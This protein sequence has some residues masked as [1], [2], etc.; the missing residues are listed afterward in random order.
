M[1]A[2]IR[3]DRV[4]PGTGVSNAVFRHDSTPTDF[5]GAILGW[6]GWE[7]A[8]A[9]TD[10][11]LAAF[12][13]CEPGSR[14]VASLVD[15]RDADHH[16]TQYVRDATGR[17]NSIQSGGAVVFLDYDEQGRIVLGRETTGRKVKYTYDDGGRIARVEKADGVVRIYAYN[18]RDRMLT[19]NENES[20]VVD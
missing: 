1:A 16:I 17:L 14:C 20:E 3:F 9:W 5:R 18:S 8:V 11:R 6:V 12:K 2:R 19:I 13:P 4:T 15:T 7:W 10:G